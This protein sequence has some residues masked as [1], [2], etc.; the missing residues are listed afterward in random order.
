MELCFALLRVAMPTRSWQSG[1]ARWKLWNGPRL[2]GRD[3]DGMYQLGNRAAILIIIIQEAYEGLTKEKIR[4]N[5]A[6]SVSG[7]AEEK[8]RRTGNPFNE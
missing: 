1:Q 6:Q 8:G 2:L 3:V 7:S 5:L 4:T